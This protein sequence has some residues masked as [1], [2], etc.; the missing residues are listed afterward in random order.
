M[1]WNIEYCRVELHLSWR[2][3]GPPFGEIS[4]GTSEYQERKIV[5]TILGQCALR[6]M[7]SVHHRGTPLSAYDI[8]MT[9]CHGCSPSLP[10]RAKNKFCEVGV[11]NRPYVPT[12]GREPKPQPQPQVSAHTRARRQVPIEKTCLGLP[13]LFAWQCRWARIDSWYSAPASPAPYIFGIA[14]CSL[15]E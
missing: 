6:C 10:S 12:V 9:R 3:F 11:V 7:N 4:P 14:W 13:Q 5:E 8:V 15:A 1:S 2:F